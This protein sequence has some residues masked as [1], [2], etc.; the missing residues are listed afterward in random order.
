MKIK[1]IKDYQCCWKK[2]DVGEV[3][4]QFAVVLIEGGFAKAVDEPP[5]NKMV[6]SPKKK[7]GYYV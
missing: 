7:K 4:P 5:K 1:M 6:S 2:G 3:S